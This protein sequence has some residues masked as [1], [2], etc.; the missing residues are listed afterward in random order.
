MTTPSK[1]YEK[2][3]SA[4]QW[5]A[6]ATALLITLIGGALY[7]NYAQRW[8]PPAELAE[9]VMRLEKLPSQIGN[10]KAVENLPIDEATLQMLDCA[11]YASRRYV[12]QLSG[13]SINCAVLVGRAGPIAVHTPEVCF[14]SRD[15]EIQSERTATGVEETPIRRHSFWKVDFNSRNA[16]ADGLRVYYAWSPGNVWNASRS[17]RF[18]F[19]GSP[20]LYKLQLA[21][22]VSP[23]VGSKGDDAGKQFL[24]EFV[25]SAWR[26]DAASDNLH[27]KDQQ[28]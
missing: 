9:G 19:A 7:G 12:N 28:P 4:R 1:A 2:S 24:E 8:N 26:H 14:S 13:Q 18:Q 17:P 3:V 27:Q 23:N 20:L 22:N 21:V 10:W 11:G 25:R 6:L 5:P 15:Y 16:L